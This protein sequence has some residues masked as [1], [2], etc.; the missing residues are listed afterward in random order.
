MRDAYLCLLSSSFTQGYSSA[1]QPV[2]VNTYI[3]DEPGYLIAC[4]VCLSSCAGIS[5]TSYFV[6]YN[7]QTDMKTRVFPFQETASLCTWAML[8]H[9]RFDFRPASSLN[10][11]SAAALDPVDSGVTYQ[12]TYYLIVSYQLV[13]IHCATCQAVSIDRWVNHA[14]CCSRI[15]SLQKLG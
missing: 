7:P 3:D 2:S 5:I 13:H 9:R 4:F 10:R 14:A 8:P 15:F 1:V 6:Y 12:T 11:P